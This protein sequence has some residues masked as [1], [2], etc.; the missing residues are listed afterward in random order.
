LAPRSRKDQKPL[1]FL[2]YV[3]ARDSLAINDV[4]SVLEDCWVGADRRYGWGHL[5]LRTRLVNAHEGLIF[6]AFRIH[7]WQSDSGPLIHPVQ[8][9]FHLP[10]HL[11]Y[12]QSLEGPMDGKLE[13]VSGRNWTH[14]RGSGGEVAR[15]EVCW[16]PGTRGCLQ[17]PRHICFEI[18]P[19]GMWRLWSPRAVPS[20]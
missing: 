15:T 14:E 3:F 18:L 10:A 2:G 17:D 5:R 8:P 11:V 20:G 9:M 6:S 16:A 7:G 13:V 19:Q 4:E 1:Y 12:D